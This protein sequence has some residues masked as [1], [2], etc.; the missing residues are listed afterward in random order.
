MLIFILQLVAAVAIN[1]VPAA[2][3]QAAVVAPAAKAV[4]TPIYPV[5]KA[6][7][8][9][10]A[11]QSF[12]TL[13][14]N[15]EEEDVAELVPVKRS[16]TRPRSKGS[17]QAPVPVPPPVTIFMPKGDVGVKGFPSWLNSGK[18]VYLDTVFMAMYA[19]EDP[20]D[21]RGRSQK[22]LDLSRQAFK[23]V[24]PNVTYELQN[25]DCLYL[26]VC[27][28]FSVFAFLCSP[29]LVGCST[30][31]RAARPHCV[32]CEEELGRALR[33]GGYRHSG[34]QAEVGCILL[35]HYRQHSHL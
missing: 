4:I 31:P 27:F 13:T 30:C 16:N 7:A 32:S 35:C 3:R 21:F 23:A 12:P 6:A 24:W 9:I 5:V 17:V 2:V 1:P 26:L 8:R 25:D 22:C 11:A 14:V 20:F 33:G 15:S 29:N 19:S 34:G 10:Q 28:L 18:E